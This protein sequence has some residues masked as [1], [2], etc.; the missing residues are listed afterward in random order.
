MR[1]SIRTVS[2][3]GVAV[4]ALLGSSATTATVAVADGS[5]AVTLPLD[6]TSVRESADT[7]TGLQATQDAQGAYRGDVTV[8][9]HADV[10]PGQQLLPSNTTVS[11][12]T[13]DGGTETATAHVSGDTGW[14]DL[15]TRGLPN[16]DDTL[17]LSAT[18][19]ADVTS[20][21]TTPVDGTLT[22]LTANPSA[23]FTAPAQNSAVWGPS[24]WTVDAVPAPGG[25]AIDRVEFYSQGY[26]ARS[27]PA[28]VATSAP[29]SYTTNATVPDPYR[30]MQAVAVDKDGYRSAPVGVVVAVEPGPTVTADGTRLLD[31]EG[32]QQLYV[33]WSGAPAAGLNFDPA[34]YNVTTWLTKAVITVDGRVLGTD[35]FSA[36]NLLC[37]HTPYYCPQTTPGSDEFDLSGLPVGSHTVTVS[38]TDNHGAVGSQSFPAVV[39]ADRLT[40]SAPTR[41]VAWGGSD[42]VYGKLTGATG[43]AIPGARI[44]LQARP[45]GS[46]TWTTVVTQALTGYSYSLSVV[47]K[48]NESL[49]VVELT[50]T[51]QVGAATAVTVRAKVTAKLSASKVRHGGHVRISG[52]VFG[53]TPGGVVRLVVDRGGKWVTLASTKQSSTGTVAFTVPERTRG[54]FYYRI[55]SPAT[56]AFGASY[57]PMLTVHVS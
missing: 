35:D 49:R 46:S 28:Y 45:A 27:K 24:T 9:F 1:S 37:L 31:A 32:T 42:G 5:A 3:L 41:A 25:A 50:G 6:I 38:V 18:E 14:F 44:A 33:R 19:G 11:Y 17:T 7:M 40:A 2:A 51:R 43:S 29:Y 57:S 34:G 36:D 15:D 47:P 23:G 21:D 22:L 13:R 39:G 8:F 52:Q 53:K 30:A 10:D 4:L 55:Y 16:G 12:L 26:S 56:T 54:T 20:T 48:Q